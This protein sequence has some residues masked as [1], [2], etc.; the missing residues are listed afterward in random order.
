MGVL[1]YLMRPVNVYNRRLE[2][3]TSISEYQESVSKPQQR[4]KKQTMMEMQV[5]MQG[6]RN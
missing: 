3:P 5:R 6:K 4:M 1:R 2:I